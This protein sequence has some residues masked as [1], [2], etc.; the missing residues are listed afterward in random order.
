MFR[1]APRVAEVQA[2]GRPARRRARPAQRLRA[3]GRVPDR[4]RAHRAAGPRRLP[5]GLRAAQEAPAGRRPVRRGAEAAAAGA[6]PQDRHRHVARRRGAARHPQGARRGAIRTRTW[7]SRRRASRATA[8]A[9]DIARGARRASAASKASTSSSSGAAAGRSRTCGPSTRSRSRAPSRACPVPVISAVGHEVDVTMADLVADLRAP[10]PSAAAEIVVAAQ[11][12]VRRAHRSPR[13]TACAA[14]A[15]DRVQQA[16]ARA[17]A[18]GRPA[19]RWRASPARLALRGRH[20]GRTAARPAARR[21]RDGAGAPAARVPG[22]AAPA[23]RAR[24]AA[25]RSAGSHDAARRRPTRG[26]GPRR[27]RMHHAAEARL[28]TLGRAARHA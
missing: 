9:A 5:A 6:A 19:R 11:G 27:V 1:S 22:A 8:R 23:R 21:V 13:P 2:R 16:A 28:G 15:R 7:S 14:A 26:C 4:L 3:E 20:V 10:T 12:R 24:P 17:A 25:Q 18:P